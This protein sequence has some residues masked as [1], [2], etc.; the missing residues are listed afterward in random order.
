[1]QLQ[2]IDGFSKWRLK[3]ARWHK[4]KYKTICTDYIN[5][6]INLNKHIGPIC[7]HFAGS[8]MASIWN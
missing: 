7:E 5:D 2:H 3:M 8:L 4:V 6:Y 1:M